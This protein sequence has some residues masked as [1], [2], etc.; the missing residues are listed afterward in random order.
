MSTISIM[1]EKNKV[2]KNWKS[3]FWPFLSRMIREAQGRCKNL[4]GIGPKGYRR[5][6]QGEPAKTSGQENSCY[7]EGTARHPVARAEKTDEKRKRK[8][9]QTRGRIVV[10]LVGHGKVSFQVIRCGK[11]LEGPEPRSEISL[12]TL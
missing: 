6:I 2:E 7:I 8:S 1:M 10:D 9:C 5:K 12:L 4:K 3:W 11:P